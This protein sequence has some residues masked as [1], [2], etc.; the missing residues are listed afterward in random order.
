[1]ASLKMP[2][3]NLVETKIAPDG[4]ANASKNRK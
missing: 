1:M 2:F 4:G 3:E